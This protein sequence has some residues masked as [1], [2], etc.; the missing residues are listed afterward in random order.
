MGG[1]VIQDCSQAAS[2]SI[3]VAQSATVIIPD[4]KGLEEKRGPKEKNRQEGVAPQQDLASQIDEDTVVTGGS[5][6]VEVSVS[7]SM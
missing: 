6:E 5:L 2:T 7:L 4:Q 3:N 1:D